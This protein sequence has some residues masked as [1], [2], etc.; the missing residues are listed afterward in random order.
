MDRREGR[1]EGCA[2]WFFIEDAIIGGIGGFVV[3]G[4]AVFS[5]SVVV[6]GCVTITV[7][8]EVGV[9]LADYGM[10]F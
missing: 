9:H 2:E 6:M 10:I 8:G 1:I 7:E 5:V 3:M 4:A